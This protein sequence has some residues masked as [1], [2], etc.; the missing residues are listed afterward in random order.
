MFDVACC[1]ASL[2]TRPER[3]CIRSCSKEWK[4]AARNADCM[5]DTLD[6]WLDR[7]LGEGELSDMSFERMY[8]E[9]YR[10]CMSGKRQSV[11]DSLVRASKR[12]RRKDRVHVVKDVC[13]FRE[14]TLKEG[15]RSVLSIF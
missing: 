13:M 3:R 5:D 15:E 4:E 6:G 10:R 9:V 12:A 14:R 7:I 8:S 11:T 1:I 2:L